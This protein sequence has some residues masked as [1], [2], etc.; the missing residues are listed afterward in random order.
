MANISG[1]KQNVGL[2]RNSYRKFLSMGEGAKAD[3]FRMLIEGYPDIEFLIQ[4]T[5]IP[6]VQ[7][8]PV[9]SYGPHGVQFTQQ[10]RF[11]NYQEVAI[12]YKEVITGK[13]YKCL[14]E[15][16]REKKYLRITLALISESEPIAKQHTSWV[17]EDA[18]LTL[19]GAD[20]DVEN[21]TLIKPSGTIHAN[22][23]TPVDPENHAIGW[24]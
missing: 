15:C 5:Q 16:V 2:V 23:V 12:T 18:W 4:A 3:D 13:V 9:E 14:R 6:P 19:E 10:G 21:N 17:F 1:V 11:K 8:E 24:E 7:R 22:W 20:L